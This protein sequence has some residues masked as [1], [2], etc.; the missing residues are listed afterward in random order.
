MKPIRT[1]IL[2]ANGAKAHI[3]LNDGPG[4]GIKAVKGLG[5]KREHPPVREIMSDQQ[6]RTFDSQGAGRHAMEPANSPERIEEQ[7]FIESIAVLL[8]SKFG[9]EAY[10]RLVI[11][12]APKTLGDIRAVLS[13][14]VRKIIYAE[15]PKD[16]TNLPLPKL[17]EHLG[18]F[19]AV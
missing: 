4:N 19:L 5:F 15:V 6:G 3:V 14:K 7:K 16:L 12:A 9:E 11:I 13:E 1:W 2:I 10:D 17:P 18:D 8:D